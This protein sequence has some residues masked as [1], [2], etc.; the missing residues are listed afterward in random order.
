[1]DPL[2]ATCTTPQ[3]PKA[4]TDSQPYWYTPFMPESVFGVPGRSE[5]EPKRRPGNNAVQRC[6]KMLPEVLQRGP[7]WSRGRLWCQNC[8]QNEPDSSMIFGPC[9]PLGADVGIQV[10]LIGISMPLMSNFYRCFEQIASMF[11][12]FLRFVPRFCPR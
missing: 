12:K 5:M 8:L 6:S 2:T 3:T 10:P 11:R 1:M 4:W 7:R 9:W